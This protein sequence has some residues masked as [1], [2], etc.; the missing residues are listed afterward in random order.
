MIATHQN[1]AAATCGQ[2][3]DTHGAS[4]GCTDNYAAWQAM[5]K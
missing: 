1:D 3:G 2:T 5:L 4:A